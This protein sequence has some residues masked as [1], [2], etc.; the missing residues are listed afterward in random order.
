LNKLSLLQVF[1]LLAT[2]FSGA[3]V[4]TAQTA[5]T[6]KDAV[7]GGECTGFLFPVSEDFGVHSQ[8]HDEAMEFW[9]RRPTPEILAC[10]E[11]IGADASGIFST[12]QLAA[13]KK[14]NKIVGRLL[15]LGVNPDGIGIQEGSSTALDS[16]VR[17]NNFAMVER[18]IKAGADTNGNGWSLAMFRSE[19]MLKLLLEAGADP[20]KTTKIGGKLPLELAVSDNDL[21]SARLLL[22][23]GAS[24]NPISYRKTHILAHAAYNDNI[25]MAS[26]LLEN[27]AKP[28]DYEATFPLAFMEWLLRSPE[29]VPLLELAL[30]LGAPADARRLTSGQPLISTAA[31]QEFDNSEALKILLE[32]GAVLGVRSEGGYT[33]LHAAALS[34][35]AANVR[36]LLDAGADPTAETDHG[37]LPF[38]MA[39]DLKNTQEYWI[40]HDAQY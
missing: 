37:E 33:P 29:R 30:E 36:V 2:C 34:G 15:E 32:H 4:G 3:A 24:P 6:S 8:Y 39:D 19:K 13:W 38:D 1:L 7:S 16:A 22:R 40:L 35:N 23:Y 25:A 9:E 27:G 28:I 12:I 11:K 14:R 21:N 5:D 20:N 26:L 17:H 10:L 18:L 31:I